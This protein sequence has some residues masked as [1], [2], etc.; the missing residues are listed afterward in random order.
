MD[1]NKLRI[2]RL[3]TL[4]VDFKIVKKIVKKAYDYEIEED[5]FGQFIENI[6]EYTDIDQNELL[7]MLEKEYYK[8]LSILSMRKM[9]RGVEYPVCEEIL[10][11][12]FSSYFKE[13]ND[14][15]F[16]DQKEHMDD[17]NE[18]YKVVGYKE[19]NSNNIINSVDIKIACRREFTKKSVLENGEVYDEDVEIFDC[20][21]F[22][23][24]LDNKLIYMFY[25]EWPASIVADNKGYTEKKRFFYD[26]FKSATKGNILSY[27][28]SDTLTKYFQEYYKDLSEGKSKKVISH[29]EAA[30][31]EE[32]F[33]A[34]KSINY[35]YKHK[36]KAIEAIKEAIDDDGYHISV[37]ECLIHGKLVKIKENGW[38]TVSDDGFC[39]EVLKYVCREF[40]GKNTA[41]D[42]C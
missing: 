2:D 31:V 13:S 29:I 26:L 15:K 38:I 17:L 4:E 33:K 24:D 9:K 5:S 34:L 42:N 39:K 23:I 30:S 25:N 22:F 20:A 27:V 7:G 19:N 37:I 18:C 40:I 21:R 41:F 36:S 8:K 6:N 11:P 35:E 14:I 28:L 1:I 10:N 16:D 3:N 12:T 32:K